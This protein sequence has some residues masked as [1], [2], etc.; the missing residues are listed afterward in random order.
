MGTHIGAAH[1]VPLDAWYIIHVHG[2]SPAHLCA[3]IPTSQDTLES[4]NTS[5]ML[6]PSWLA[7]ETAS[8]EMGSSP[9]RRAHLAFVR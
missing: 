1:I 5:A 9:R 4:T 7:G 3:F 8:H 6:G 2:F